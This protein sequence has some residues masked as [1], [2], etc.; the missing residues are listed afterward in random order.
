MCLRFQDCIKSQTVINLN[1]F[2]FRFTL[3]ISQRKERSKQKRGMQKRVHNCQVSYALLNRML[4]SD[5]LHYYFL[6]I[7]TENQMVKVDGKIF[8]EVMFILIKKQVHQTVPALLKSLLLHCLFCF[9]SCLHSQTGS[10]SVAVG[11]LLAAA[12]F[13]LPSYKG[14]GERSE[15][16]GM[17]GE[18]RSMVLRISVYRDRQLLSSNYNTK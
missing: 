13:V 3:D 17:G 10:P 18:S 2:L 5:S 15:C 16:K 1:S 7:Q 6:K 12:H 14:C 9:L 8:L 11:Y 4:F